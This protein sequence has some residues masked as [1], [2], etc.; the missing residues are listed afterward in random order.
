M[1]LTNGF[2]KRKYRL[3]FWASLFGW[4]ISIMNSLVDSIFAGIFISE[5]AVSAVELVSPIYGIIMFPCLFAVVGSS[6]LYSRYA[7]A[8]EK[9]KAYGIAGMGMIIAVIISVVSSIMMICM[10]D[11]YFAY[12]SS[13]PVIESYAREYYEALIIYTFINPIYW[14][15]YYLVAADGDASANACSDA[16]CA[17]G[18][19]FASLL[20]VRRFGIRGIA[21][22]TILSMLLGGVVIIVHFFSKRNSIRFSWHFGSKEFLEMFKLGSTTSLTY[23]YIAIVDILLN[24]YVIEEFGDSY[25]PAYMIINTMI[26][27]AGCFICGIDA[28]TPFINV[29]Y[30]EGNPTGMKKIMKYVNRYTIVTSLA[31]TAAGF[32]L[33]AYVPQLYGISDPAAYD[34]SVYAAKGIA[35]SYIL[36]A[37]VYELSTYYIKTGKEILA[38]SMTILYNLIFPLAFA[39]PFAEPF[40]FKGLVW[41]FILTPAACLILTF[42]IIVIKYGIKEIPFIPIRSE[43]K[44]SIYELAVKPEE[45]IELQSLVGKDLDAE[46]VDVK[47]SERIKLIIE[48]TLMTVF[49]KNSGKKILADCTIIVS[50]SEIQLITRDNGI[51]FDITDPDLA[52]GSLSEYVAA[53]LMSVGQDNSYLTTTSFNRNSYTW[54]R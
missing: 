27:F 8:F 25:L 23:L 20:F 50:D 26:N 28:G 22:G 42:V 47:T 2:L 3:L 45:I 54:K 13:S 14:S 38:N 41:D 52:L 9:E 6:T 29:C 46:G 35:L 15:S 40:G 37:F 49:E 39:V 12:Y 51:I 18:N 36:C 53:R 1:S 24:K 43:N 32:I 48:E 5:E 21:Y 11:I 31:F 17:F 34:A 16:I 19:L 44:I 10:E 33:S 7:G 4:T 30:G